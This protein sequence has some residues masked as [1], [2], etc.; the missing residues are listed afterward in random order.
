MVDYAPWKLKEFGAAYLG[1]AKGTDIGKASAGSDEVDHMFGV[2]SKCCEQPALEAAEDM[3]LAEW[4]ESVWGLLNNLTEDM[5][6]MDD[7]GRSFANQWRQSTKHIELT[8]NQAGALVRTMVTRLR[9]E[10]ITRN[11]EISGNFEE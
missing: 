5:E 10:I 2:F 9:F 6:L 7:Y 3:D 11:Q 4:L 1:T 8:P